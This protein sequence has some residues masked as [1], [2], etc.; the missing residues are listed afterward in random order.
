MFDPFF[1]TKFTGRGLGLSSVFG[2]LKAHRGTIKVESEYGKGSAFTI[3]FPALEVSSVYQDEYTKKET[4]KRANN[5]ILFVDDEI[6][7]RTIGEKLLTKKGFNVLTAEN[8][9]E[10]L[11]IYTDNQ[12]DIYVFLRTS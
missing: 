2:V 10:A 4:L 9:E 11:K 6:L 1:T 5:T 7:I 3:L 8:G 12:N